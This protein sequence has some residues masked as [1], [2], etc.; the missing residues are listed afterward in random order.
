VDE[1]HA[2]YAIWRLRTGR[3]LK[4]GAPIS[5]APFFVFDPWRADPARG[6]GKGV[7]LGMVAGPDDDGG[8]DRQFKS[9]YSPCT[10]SPYINFNKKTLPIKYL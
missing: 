2:R 6:S 1:D 10:D 7:L 4:G 3:Y 5:G 9:L 8:V